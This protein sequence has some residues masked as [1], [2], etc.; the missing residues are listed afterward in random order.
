VLINHSHRVFFWANEI[1][2][3]T[4]QKFDAEACVQ[5]PWPST[6]WVCLRSSS[7]PYRFDVDSANAVRQCLENHGVPSA[8]VQMA[9][10]QNRFTQPRHRPYK[11]LEVELLSNRGP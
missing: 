5:P 4:G 9:R 8:R 7:A 1:A 11:P 2:R 3:Q 10:T 6:I